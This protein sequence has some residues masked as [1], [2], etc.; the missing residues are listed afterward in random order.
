MPQWKSIVMYTVGNIEENKCSKLLNFLIS[1]TFPLSE[2]VYKLDAHIH[3]IL[4]HSPAINTAR[5]KD[6]ST[7]CVAFVAHITFARWRKKTLYINLHHGLGQ[8]HQE[9][10]PHP[11]LCLQSTP[12]SLLALLSSRRPVNIRQTSCQ[13]KHGAVNT[14]TRPAAIASSSCNTV[15]TIPDTLVCARYS[16]L[17]EKPKFHSAATYKCYHSCG[18]VILYNKVNLNYI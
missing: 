13:F 9:H 16:F 10:C 6:I 7:K 1:A 15:H 17:R 14:L 2:N 4:K 3:F 18:N 11:V 8:P 5:S 12:S